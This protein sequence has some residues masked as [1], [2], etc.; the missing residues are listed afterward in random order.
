VK[1]YERFGERVQ[2]MRF[3]KG[4]SGR[5]LAAR[6][7]IAESSLR[8]IENGTSKMPGFVTAARIAQALD[9]DLFMLS[10]GVPE[11]ELPDDVDLS[12]L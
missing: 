3:A 1:A 9:T 2:Q 5:A 10:F 11:A 7:G 6:A 8:R 12:D 4:L